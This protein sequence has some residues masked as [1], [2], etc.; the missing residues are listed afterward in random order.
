MGVQFTQCGVYVLGGP[1]GSGKS[2]WLVRQVGGLLLR[3]RHVSTNLRLRPA[4]LAHYLGMTFDQVNELLHLRE[5]LPALLLAGNKEEWARELGNHVVVVD[6]ALRWFPPGQGPQFKA[7][8]S[9]LQVHRHMGITIIFAAPSVAGD[10]LCK[11]IRDKVT[12][13]YQAVDFRTVKILGVFPGPPLQVVKC[14]IGRS[15]RCAWLERNPIDR[16]VECYDAVAGVVGDNIEDVVSS[17]DLQDKGALEK[18]SRLAAAVVLVGVGLYTAWGLRHLWSV[19]HTKQPGAAA[20]PAAPLLPADK[21]LAAMKARGAA[22]RKQDVPAGHVRGRSGP[23]WVVD[24][25]NGVTVVVPDRAV[26]DE[27][28]AVAWAVANQ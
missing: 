24:L 3:G 2:R 5:D 9:C 22:M 20:V 8:D 21:V 7:F 17:R 4:E 6:E 18:S 19:A 11:P 25:A 28:S 14:F 16:I 23:F 13:R 12:E 27:S 15:N 26:T 10:C 1:T